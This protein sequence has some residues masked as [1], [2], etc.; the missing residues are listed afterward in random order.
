M[1]IFAD[2]FAISFELRHDNPHFSFETQPLQQIEEQL[3]C[4]DIFFQNQVFYADATGIK[5]KEILR[6]HRDP[7]IALRRAHLIL[8]FGSREEKH[9]FE[10]RYLE[11]YRMIKAAGG[12]V[13]NSHDELL[14]IFRD[15]KWDLPKGK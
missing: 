7:R 12:L 1:K 13:L 4:G 2:N 8:L 14:M 11:A 10:T 6:I 9:R 5:R 15:G 3:L